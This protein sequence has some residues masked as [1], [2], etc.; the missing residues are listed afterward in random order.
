MFYDF[1]SDHACLVWI[2]GHSFVHW[3][4]ERANVRPNDH[5]LGFPRSEASI[6]WIG[7]LGLLWSRV[8]PEVHRVSRW[9]RALDVLVLHAEGNDLGVR[10]SRHLIR[11]VNFSSHSDGLV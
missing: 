8:V 10:S 11:D 5:Q 9:D 2:L 3:G 7:V 4:A 6:R 1:F